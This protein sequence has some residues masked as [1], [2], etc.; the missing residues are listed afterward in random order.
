MRQWHREN[1]H[2]QTRGEGLREAGVGLWWCHHPGFSSCD[3]L[4]S[5][6]CLSVIFLLIYILV[7]YWLTANCLCANANADHPNSKAS[8]SK[9]AIHLSPQRLRVVIQITLC[10]VTVCVPSSKTCW[11]LVELIKVQDKYTVADTN[12]SLIKP[13]CLCLSGILL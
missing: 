10:H 2:L 8:Y 13:T 9:M 4:C 3:T 11:H 6:M 7:L 5:A 1:R 12:I